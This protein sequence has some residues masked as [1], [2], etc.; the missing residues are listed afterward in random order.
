MANQPMGA[1][2][3]LA[4]DDHYVPSIQGYCESGFGR[5]ADVFAAQLESGLHIGGS[6]QV[7]LDGKKPV[8][9]IWG[10]SADPAR[11]MSW[12]EHTN[13]PIGSPGKALASTAMLILVDRALLD[14]HKP[15]PGGRQARSTASTQ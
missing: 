6:V 14:L 10:G 11:G 5:V 15:V 2:F 9:Q 1:D 12:A 13:T 8:V 4:S 3:W 7:Y